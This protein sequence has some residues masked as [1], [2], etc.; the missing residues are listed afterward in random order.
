MAVAA[1]ALEAEAVEIVEV[2]MAKEDEE[3][4]NVK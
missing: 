1:P 4:K 2:E 3:K